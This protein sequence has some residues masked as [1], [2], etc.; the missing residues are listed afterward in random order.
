M[1]ATLPSGLKREIENYKS[2]LLVEKDKGEEAKEVFIKFNKD[3]L[4]KL[5]GC[6]NFYELVAAGQEFFTRQS[7]IVQS[8]VNADREIQNAQK[9]LERGIEDHY[10]PED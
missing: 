1:A 10:E 9:T 5:K 8:N 6:Q 7:A 3:F 2:K 4:E